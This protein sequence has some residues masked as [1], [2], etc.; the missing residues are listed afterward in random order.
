MPVG[1]KGQPLR[2]GCSASEG[3][4][5]ICNKN[6]AA[7]AEDDRFFYAASDVCIPD[8]L[9]LAKLYMEIGKGGMSTL[10]STISSLPSRPESRISGAAAA[11]FD[12]GSINLN[13]LPRSNVEFVEKLGEGEFG[14]V[15][16]CRLIDAISGGRL[17]AVKSLRIGC[18]DGAR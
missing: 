13:E 11:S 1:C 15:H 6:A 10:P 5:T 17:V 16:L 12:L 14:E 3:N 7:A 18:N 9:D 4:S 8:S 2:L